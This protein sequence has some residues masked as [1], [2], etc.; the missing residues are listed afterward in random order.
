M[1]SIRDDTDM[2]LQA[3]VQWFVSLSTSDSVSHK[4]I[5]G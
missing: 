3:L 4:L 1:D 2:V 5:W